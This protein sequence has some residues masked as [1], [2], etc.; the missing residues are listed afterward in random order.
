MSIISVEPTDEAAQ[1]VL[2]V[3]SCEVVRAGLASV[4]SAIPFVT[5]VVSAPTIADALHTVRNRR[6]HTVL[7]AETFAG[8]EVSALIAEIE[9]R[10]LKHLLTVQTQKSLECPQV[11]DLLHD[12]VLVIDDL[13]AATMSDALLRVAR[14]QTVLPARLLQPMLRASA[15]RELIR[16][17]PLPNLT[18]RELQILSLVSEGMSNKQIARIATITEHGVKRHVANVL[19]KLNSPNRTQAV[20]YALQHGLLAS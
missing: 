8:D 14:D 1:A 10:R 18:Q 9:H 3:H 13:T 20:A 15:H 17:V 11:L 2:I 4:A 16:A 6:V 5:S 12:G 19:A 7:V